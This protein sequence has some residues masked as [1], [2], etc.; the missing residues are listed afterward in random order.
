MMKFP[1]PV[2]LHRR[3]SP[4]LLILWMLASAGCFVERPPGHSF[5]HSHKQAD[6]RSGKHLRYQE[7]E[8][9]EWQKPEQVVAAL[10]L[11]PGQA[12]ADL[13]AGTGYF[14]FRLAAAVG[15]TGQVYA[16]DI[17][18]EMIDILDDQKIRK[19]AV[20][21]KS[22]LAKEHDPLLPKPVGLIF[23]V[24]STHHIKERVDYF[25]NAARYLKPGGR[26]AVV[27]FKEGA[28]R[29]FVKRQT[30]LDEF[31]AAGYTFVQEFDFLPK[32]NFMVF[33]WEQ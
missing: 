28:F 10:N 32:Q 5:G 3:L 19:Q 12:V 30:L 26:V 7:P 27:D 14:T 24:N 17:D 25:K 16:V 13:G 21:V 29:H 4:V 33:R 18:Q 11:Q 8:R 31:K 15:D 23:A 2:L 22:V 20:N 1:K 6:K 9:D